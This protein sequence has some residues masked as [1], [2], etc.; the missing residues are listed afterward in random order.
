MLPGLHALPA[1]V[2]E[3]Y[4]T[5]PSVASFSLSAGGDGAS[6]DQFWGLLSSGSGTLDTH[7]VRVQAREQADRIEAVEEASDSAPTP[8][9]SEVTMLEYLFHAY[10]K[11]AVVGA[12][13]AVKEG[14]DKVA[15]HVAVVLDHA[16]GN[17][18][19]DS[20]QQRV[21]RYV[22]GIERRLAE[23][24]K[25]GIAGLNLARNL[26]VLPTAAIAESW[27]PGP[28]GHV[29]GASD[30]ALDAAMR[31]WLA[32]A[33]GTAQRMGSWVRQLI[34]LLPL[35]IACA[36]DNSFVLMADGVQRSQ[37]V[38]STQE[39]VDA[40]SFGLLDAVL[41]SWWGEIAVVS[42]MG[43]Q[44]TG[45]SYTLNHLF[46]TSFQISGACCTDSCWMGLCQVGRVLFVILDFEGLGSF[47]RTE[48][49][50]MLLAVFDAAVSNYTLFKTEF[51]LDRDLEAMFSRF[52]SGTGL[53]KGD[54]RLFKGCFCI[55]VKDVPD[56]DIHSVNQ[57]FHAKIAMS[58]RPRAGREVADNFIKE[59]YGGEFAVFP[60]PPLGRPEFYSSLK[61]MFAVI[62]RRPKQ[63]TSGGASFSSFMK[64][65][66]S[67]LI[68]KDWTTLEGQSP[69]ASD[70]ALVEEAALSSLDTG[71]V[72][73]SP[74]LA[75]ALP[76]GQGVGIPAVQVPDNLIVL[77]GR[78]QEALI[79]K[80]LEV[81][82]KDVE[83]EQ[84][85][86]EAA[87]P[88]FVKAVVERR[89]S[90]V[91]EWVEANLMRLQGP[92][93]RLDDCAVRFMDDVASKLQVLRN[94]WQLCGSSCS[95]CFMSC[96]LPK[97]HAAAEH[98]CMGLHTCKSTCSFCEE[99][100]AHKGSAHP[101][102]HKCEEKMGHGGT[103]CCKQK[104]HTC[105]ARCDMAG[106]L[107]CNHR[108][109]LKAGHERLVGE[110]GH[111][112]NSPVHL[113]GAPCSASNCGGRCQIV[114]DKAHT[115][116]K[117]AEV[118]CLHA[119][120]VRGC[121]YTC[122]SRDHFHHTSLSQLYLA[123]AGGAGPSSASQ[124]AAE[125]DDGM[126]FCGREHP[127]AE[128]CESEG[129][130][131]LSI[132]HVN[133][134]QEDVFIGARSTFT[135]TTVAEA[136]GKREECAIRVPP[137]KLCHEGPHTH[138]LDPRVVHTCGAK[139]PTCLY[140][141]ELPFGHAGNHR[142]A[143]GMMRTCRW[144]SD[145]D[146]I[147]VGE[148]KYVRGESGHAEMCN[149]LC[150]A[151][152]Q[153]HIH[154]M[155]CDADDPKQCTHSSRDGRRHETCRYGPDEDV[156]K[157]E[158]THAH[159][160]ETIGWHDSCSAAEREVFA[161]CSHQCDPRQHEEEGALPSF[162]VLGLW[163]DPADQARQPWQDLL[164]A[165]S[166]FVAERVSKG[167]PDLV[168]VVIY[169]H[170]A[171][172]QCEGVP[173]ANCPV[174][175][176]PFRGGATDFALALS[177]AGDIIA[178]VHAREG[179]TYTPLLLF[180][181]D[182]QEKSGTA[183]MN[184]LRT[185]FGP[186]GL[187]V[188]TV[189]F[190]SCEFSMLQ[191]L[192]QTGQGIFEESV[193][194]I[195]LG[196][197]FVRIASSMVQRA[198]L[199]PSRQRRRTTPQGVPEFMATIPHPFPPGL[200]PGLRSM[201]SGKMLEACR[202]FE[203]VHAAAAPG[204]VT[205]A[206]LLLLHRAQEHAYAKLFLDMDCGPDTF[207]PWFKDQA[208]EIVARTQQALGAQAGA[209]DSNSQPV[210]LDVAARWRDTVA[211]TGVAI[212]AM[213]KLLEMTG[214]EPVKEQ[215][216][217]IYHWVCIA[218]RR[219]E[220]VHEKRL[221]VVLA[222][223]PGTGKTTVARLYG[224]FLV[225]LGVLSGSAM[226]ETT[227]A[228]L[229]Q[230]GVDELKE[231]LEA[232]DEG[233]GVLFIDEAYQVNPKSE[234]YGQRVLNY[235]LEEVENKIG[236][237]VVALAGYKSKMEALF[238]HNE[239][240]PERFPYKFAFEDYEDSELMAMLQKRIVKKIPSPDL[241]IEGGMD[242]KPMRILHDPPPGPW[243]RQGGLWQRARG[244]QPVGQDHGAAGDAAC[245]RGG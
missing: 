190:G 138:S 176:L 125:D 131:R 39:A 9:A 27:V 214:L 8:A 119:C 226:E 67:K 187:L 240:L 232:I 152:G 103:H 26:V 129:I 4:G 144:V 123:E 181:S 161:K 135:Y 241:S 97:S 81:Y 94:E 12:A 231:L 107:N 60:F 18:S 54:E 172:V 16:G 38:R 59:M 89:C 192:A 17:A 177:T 195:A 140:F 46:G 159:Y 66:M 216:L 225:S 44:S 104:P 61:T 175:S 35:Q 133:K 55:V 93:G 150:Q 108:C 83:V 148:R 118:M 169:N 162:C 64:H 174:N 203:R 84:P 90:R 221:N 19:R 77:R 113:C 218:Q 71:Q 126:H 171:I 52:Q 80:L 56:R 20:L 6:W 36:E 235:L 87:F 79:Q 213:D 69:D 219:G 211:K 48:Q 182:G 143:H 215:F 167:A 242:G 160:W 74:E 208:A 109:S 76:D 210:A 134:V 212:P 202:M 116:H 115:V 165:V 5:P 65:L 121:T 33:A 194:G 151:M 3:H 96:L 34:C 224:E 57:E 156:P 179:G 170:L 207:W 222:G 68:L 21:G 188:Y 238:E 186:D 88:A 25:P 49:E 120:A 32:S 230:E 85:R 185:R 31:S 41:D 155:T 50:D 209:E 193:D 10:D 82:C 127:C 228:R 191:S 145:R 92:D 227:G 206:Q 112:C 234:M 244:G 13:V 178:R 100:A 117:C 62:A 229:V 245:W 99:A 70:G 201:A 163:H 124:G 47:E 196:D 51:C 243:P 130:C 128:P 37:H 237:L 146:D 63:F 28:G 183:E 7:H 205:D 111:V 29:P 142:G 73:G 45:K 30:V 149:M 101:L 132:Q 198:S 199:M 86:W 184:Q 158:L 236:K 180:M 23:G 75:S 78:E 157:D 102:L 164:Q 173:I 72:V 98:T 43:K 24:Y 200:A 58:T 197:T 233:G 223:N 42:S 147:D 154:V 139:C 204:A 1:K 95:H 114:H 106:L 239:G 220:S 11:F 14:L 15:M 166:R 91:Q 137:F 136:N 189:G 53:L 217:G 40:I 110:G 122:S 141:C 2:V 22:D 105:Q 153:G 168:S